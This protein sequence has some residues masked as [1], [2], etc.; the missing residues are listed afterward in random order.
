MEKRLR[1]RLHRAAVLI[2]AAGVLLLAAEA[3]VAAFLARSVVEV[4]NEQ[5]RAETDEY[6]NRL[7]KQMS[8]DYQILTTMSSFLEFSNVDEAENFDEIL[9][10]ANLRNDFVS[11][12]YFPLNG[13]GVLA[14]LGQPVRGGVELTELQPEVQEVVAQAWQGE[15]AL[16]DLVQSELT[17]EKV[18]IYA[19]PVSRNGVTMGALIASDQVEIFSDI[20]SGNTVLSGN[21][22]IH[23]LNS[24]GE[25]LIHSQNS[26][27]EESAASIYEEPY[28]NGGQ[29]AEDIRTAMAAGESVYS[30]F[31]Y[32]GRSYQVLLEP[33][34]IKDWY[35]LC[36]SR[37]QEA[38][39]L[40]R[41]VTVITATFAVLL[42]M[43]VTLL[44]YGYRLTRRNDRELRELAFHDALTGGD[45][46]RGF[47]LK[48]QEALSQR[49]DVNLAALDVRQ[50]KF[51]NEI[52][53]RERADKLLCHIHRQ[54]QARLE[55]GE[56]CC[57]D[58][59]DL[60][61]A[62]LLNADPAQAAARLRNIMDEAC[63]AALHDANSDYHILLYAGM[64]AAPQC[65]ASGKVD[66]VLTHAMFAL[67][68]AKGASSNTV[69]TYDTE[70]HKKEEVANYVE[71]H[72][73]QAL[74]SGEF[75]MYLQPKIDLTSGRLGGA[76]ALVRWT[77]GTGRILYPDQFIPLFEQN[78]FSV[79]LDLYMVEC[80]C[81]QL[82]AWLDQGIQPPPLSVNQSK[83][84]FFEADYIQKLE[85]LTE[86]YQIPASWIT[87]EILEGL[88]LENAGE[89]NARISQLQGIGFRISM[90]D[91][92]SGYSSL[93]TLSSLQ[94]DEL[95]LDRGFLKEAADKNDPRSR[96]IMEQVV[97]MAKQLGISVVVEGVETQ[98][99]EALIRSLDCDFGQGYY[100]SRP[101]T[102]EEFT[103]RYWGV[104]E[105]APQEAAP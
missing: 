33:V 52:F 91:F 40:Y 47:T 22:H 25:L 6:K 45:N 8:S 21:G 86:R 20:L 75:R 60:F 76:E 17:Q 27:V 12:A 97:Q 39:E 72:M 11:M 54:L 77:T 36:V 87:L 1:E 35:M 10:E 78:G 71:S 100:Y 105:D 49:R 74:Q 44:V 66:D 2:V 70:L 24:R 82:R 88:A 58:S 46:L 28:F 99:N 80:A 57:R 43:M 32:E 41:I 81:K 83:L 37:V 65:A 5:M 93:N 23:L 48:L 16:S 42:L 7:E 13:P 53:G 55:E 19:I 90:D 92:G 84:L 94:I 103:A 26:V 18:F 96:V 68:R 31:R 73:H 3:G 14:V 59:A 79:S 63:A 69:W 104:P 4:T 101:I 102:V 56:F 85:R 62:V 15:M 95:K 98:E 51:I 50:F 38:G 34:G 9:N 89:L 67:E 61:Y 29:K 30:S 64:V